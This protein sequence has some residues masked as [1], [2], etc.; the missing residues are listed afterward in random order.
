MTIL[1]ARKMIVCPF[2]FSRFRADEVRFR[3]IEP[4]CTARAPDLIWAAATG[5]TSSAPTGK[6][7]EISR[8]SFM[9]SLSMPR[10]ARCDI[11]SHETKSR[12][13]PTCHFELSLDAG[14]IDD[15]VIAIIGGRDTGKSHYIATLIER[16]DHEIGETFGF[17]I[18]RLGEGTRQRYLDDFHAPL[19]LRKRIL[20][21][22]QSAVTDGRVKLPMTFRFTLGKGRRQRALNLSF[23]DTAGEDMNSLDA[24]SVEARYICGASGIIFLLDPLQIES[25][26]QQLPGAHL[27]NVDPQAEPTYIIERLRELFERQLNLSPTKPVQTPIAFALSKIDALFPLID[28]GSI[29]RRPGEHFGYVNLPEVRSIHT[30]IWSYLQTWMG[31][32]FASRV[33]HGFQKYHFFGVSALG[34]QPGIDGNVG[35]VSSLRVED[36]LLWILHELG[37]VPAR[38]PKGS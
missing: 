7:L 21:Q 36:P 18:R 20:Q 3:C 15:R 12:L 19:F 32:G 29:L 17:S 8:S 24:M 25:V 38:N 23:F 26:R 28:A 14:M 9:N 11:C 35:S 37:V 16:L 5:Q 6:A 10:S 22:T 2:C 30:E 13:C 1:R 33:E 31:S 4:R 27:P 34:H